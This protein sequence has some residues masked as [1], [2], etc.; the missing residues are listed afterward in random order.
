MMQGLAN[1]EYTNLYCSKSKI[2]TCFGCSRQILT[3]LYFR[4]R[5]IKDGFLEP[6]FAW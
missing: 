1:P 4:K 6:T 2:S 5:N 3:G